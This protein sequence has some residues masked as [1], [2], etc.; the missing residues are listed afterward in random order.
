MTKPTVNKLVLLQHH[1]DT[2]SLIDY[3]PLRPLPLPVCH[4]FEN[5][6][7]VIKHLLSK[8]ATHK[9]FCIRWDVTG[10]HI[11]GGELG[12]ILETVF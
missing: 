7:K 6:L 5:V 10:F 8:I 9:Q 3:L 11:E 12:S 4:H 1:R 2:R